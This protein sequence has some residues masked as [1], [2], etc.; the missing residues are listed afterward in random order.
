MLLLEKSMPGIT[1]RRMKT[2]GWLMSQTTFIEFDNVRAP[3][4]NLIGQE[5]HGFKYT[6][7]NFNHERFLMTTQMVRFSRICL[8]EA[9]TFAR[10][11][12]TFGKRLIDHQVI[13]HKIAEM[14][15]GLEGTQRALE[16]YAYQVKSG[17]PDAELAGYMALI[18]V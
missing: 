3:V 5:G 4:S 1:C 16:N 12:K 15:R 17:V 14:A 18:K 11:R 2:Q 13:R 10:R 8:E 7:V 6:L 9:I